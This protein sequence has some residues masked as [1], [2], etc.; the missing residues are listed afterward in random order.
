MKRNLKNGLS[1][2][3]DYLLFSAAAIDDKFG[4]WDGMGVKW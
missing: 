4:F 1:W 3:K 2:N